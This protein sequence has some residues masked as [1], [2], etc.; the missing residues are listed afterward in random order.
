MKWWFPEAPTNLP[1]MSSASRQS[2]QNSARCFQAE[3]TD[4][5]FSTFPIK[6]TVQMNPLEQRIQ[7]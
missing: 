5:R 1:L 7:L 6:V 4:M 3:D 2:G